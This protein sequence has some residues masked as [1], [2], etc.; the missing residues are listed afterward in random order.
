[1]TL[2]YKCLIGSRLYGT[3]RPDSDY[4]WFEVYSSGRTRQKVTKEQDVI[5]TS[6]TTFMRYAANGAHQHLE[7]MFAPDACVYADTFPDLRRSYRCDTIKTAL[8]Y[9]RTIK[10]FLATQHTDKRGDKAIKTALRMVYN[11]EEILLYARFNPRLPTETVQL[12]QSL[13]RDEAHDMVE[14]RLNLLGERYEL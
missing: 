7:A 11:L 14:Q 8:L 10:N 5:R 9:K 13:T 1:M 6:L 3:N 2:L 4:D 12:L